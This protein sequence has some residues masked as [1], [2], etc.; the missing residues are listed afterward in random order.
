[1][2]AFRETFPF[3]W[4][5]DTGCIT[6]IVVIRVRQITSCTS[7]TFSPITQFKAAI[8]LFMFNRK[9]F[10]YGALTLF[11]FIFSFYHSKY[12]RT[13]ID[14]KLALFLGLYITRHYGLL[15]TMLFF[16]LTDII[17]AIL[18]GESVSG[19][20]L[21]F[22]GWYFIVNAIVLLFPA[23]PMSQLG[24]ILVIVESVGSIYINSQIAGIPGFLSIWIQLINIMA[25][26]VYFLTLGNIMEF[27]FMAI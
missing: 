18:G 15:F 26:I 21:F 25:R 6:R 20:D 8:V 27:L 14:F 11:S 17:P 1:M 22:F 2:H 4:L 9:Y 7:A 13:P 12:N 24:P 16:I 23:M 19:P 3:K 5:A 10:L